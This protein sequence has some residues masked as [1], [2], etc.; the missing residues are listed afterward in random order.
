M[1]QFKNQLAAQIEDRNVRDLDIKLKVSQQQ[2]EEF[3][4]LAE[5]RLNEM[6]AIKS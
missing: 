1:I 3:R 5:R 2:C 6:Q 4:H